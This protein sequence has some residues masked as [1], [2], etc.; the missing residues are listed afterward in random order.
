MIYD[1]FPP[2]RH[3]RTLP[4]YRT[5][6]IQNI[7]KKCMVLSQAFPLIWFLVFSFENKGSTWE[8]TEAQ[9]YL[10]T[11]PYRSIFCIIEA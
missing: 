10:N 8:I 9:A 3:D 7:P 11:S 6:K 5:T 1:S 2:L 4:K